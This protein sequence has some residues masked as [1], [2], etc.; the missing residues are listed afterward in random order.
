MCRVLRITLYF[1]EFTVEL[2]SLERAAGTEVMIAVHSLVAKDKG[3]VQFLAMYLVAP[4]NMHSLLFKHCFHFAGSN[5]LFLPRTDSAVVIG[6]ELENFWKLLLLSFGANV[7]RVDLTG[8]EVLN[9][10]SADLPLLWESLQI[11]S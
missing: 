1:F 3:L 6:V 10:A 2:E 9:T 8:V 11:H 7:R 5:L 4:Q